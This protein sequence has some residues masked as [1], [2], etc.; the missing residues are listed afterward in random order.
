MFDIN[1]IY[2]K[3]E[4]SINSKERIKD[5]ILNENR[6]SNFIAFVFG[7]IIAHCTDFYCVSYTVK[8]LFN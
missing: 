7:F 3:A 6:I 1:K 2:M 8:S 4:K 5:Y